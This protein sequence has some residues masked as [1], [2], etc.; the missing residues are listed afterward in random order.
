MTESARNLGLDQQECFGCE[1]EVDEVFLPR[2]KSFAGAHSLI[3]YGSSRHN[4]IR[5]LHQRIY[6]PLSIILPSRNNPKKQLRSG[7]SAAG[8]PM[9]EGSDGWLAHIRLEDFGLSFD[10]KSK[11]HLRRLLD[12]L[13]SFQ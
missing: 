13:P 7:Q 3:T 8:V 4:E 11:D 12:K 5:D 9:T 10:S 2:M 6:P 1:D